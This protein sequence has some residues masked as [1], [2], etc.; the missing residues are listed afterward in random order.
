[1]WGT[2]AQGDCLWVSP[3]PFDSLQAGD[4]VAFDSGGKIVVHRIVERMDTGFAT[5]GDGNGSRD[6][7][8]LTAD[9]L[10][11]KVMERERKGVRKTVTGGARGRRRAL[12]LQAAVRI[13]LIFVSRLARLS[14]MVLA[15]R[16]VSLCWRPSLI[17]VRFISPTGSVTKFIHRGRT[18]A[19]WKPHACQWECRMPYDLILSPP[20]R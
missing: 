16:M 3:V 10:V 14:R 18:V 2:L 19:S 20:A 6:S 11:G 13:R 4:V 7:A 1:M 8:P 12:V 15:R 5:R 17:C 9:R